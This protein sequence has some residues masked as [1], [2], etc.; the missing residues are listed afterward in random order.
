MGFFYKNV[1]PAVN[2]ATLLHLSCISLIIILL[3]CDYS[4]P[5]QSFHCKAADRLLIGPKG[6]WRGTFTYSTTAVNYKTLLVGL[7]RLLLHNIEQDFQVF[8][9]AVNSQLFS[10]DIGGG[11]GGLGSVYPRPQR[12]YRNARLTFP[13][14]FGEILQPIP[15]N[16][17]QPLLVILQ[18]ALTRGGERV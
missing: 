9:R 17:V 18:V 12:E 16:P 4:G 6:D 13:S 2:P 3:M 1:F 7:A 11:A 5:P 10:H 8:I 14:H 15:P